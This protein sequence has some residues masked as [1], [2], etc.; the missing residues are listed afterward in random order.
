M[1]NNNSK[2]RGKPTGGVSLIEVSMQDV[3][4]VCNSSAVVTIGRVWAEKMGIIKSPRDNASK[5][6][7]QDFLFD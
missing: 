2:K 1:N 5:N 7:E 4:N 3:M 6:L